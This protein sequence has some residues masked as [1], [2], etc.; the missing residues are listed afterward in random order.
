[1]LVNLPPSHVGCVTELLGTAI[2]EGLTSVLLHV[3]DAEKSLEAIQQ[4][5]VTV[6]G[7]IPALFT[8]EWNHPRFR[9]FD[10]RSLRVA[11]YGGQAVPRAFLDRLR[12]MA[13]EIGTGCHAMS[14]A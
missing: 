6:L 14:Q 7:Q 12:Q 11:I 3:F 13:P 8:L 1:M 9:D 10:L 5:R 4:H 2:Y